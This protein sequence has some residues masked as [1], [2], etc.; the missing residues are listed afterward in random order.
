MSD[1]YRIGAP[2]SKL[3]FD[4]I[5]VHDKDWRLGKAAPPWLEE[6][7]WDDPTQLRRLVEECA[8]YFRREFRYDF[9]P[10]S[11]TEMSCPD[12]FT[13]KTA[14][15][16]FTHPECCLDINKSTGDLIRKLRVVGACCF[17]WRVWTDR[18]HGYAMQW[19]WLHP[20]VRNKGYLKLCWPYFL[21]RFG[22]FLVE[23]PLSPAMRHFVKK[24]GTADQ[25]PYMQEANKTP[26]VEAY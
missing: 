15:Y 20:Y 18:P 7:T 23:P 22:E 10:Y 24:Y 11:A 14:A 21:H 8:R 16:V 13:H 26:P 19:I 17:R 12:A 4:R 1:R 25:W 3:L 6:I 2:T 9:V 5:C